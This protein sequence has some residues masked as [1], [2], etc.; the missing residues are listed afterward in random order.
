MAMA[1]AGF[2]PVMGHRSGGSDP[3]PALGTGS[4]GGRASPQGIP[5]MWGR[6]CTPIC[7]LQEIAFCCS[8]HLYVQAYMI[9]WKGSKA[10]W[11]VLAYGT[12]P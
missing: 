9:A 11:C 7:T 10:G 12:A 4:A 1:G 5:C 6:G 2:A 3:G 8:V